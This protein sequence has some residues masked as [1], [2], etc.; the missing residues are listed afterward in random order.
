LFNSVP[1]KYID[2]FFHNSAVRL[3]AKSPYSPE[4]TMRLFLALILTLICAAAPV[5]AFADPT[6]EFQLE[7]R[8]YIERVA[9]L[10]RQ[11]LILQQVQ[12]ENP[13]VTVSLR[14]SAKGKFETERIE[15]GSGDPSF[16]M[17]VE[18]A[19]SKSIPILPVPP[20]PPG[21]TG[22]F[23]FSVRVCGGIC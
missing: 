23:T 5:Q 16:D 14:F 9:F 1:Q 3:A 7:Q 17:S 13:E 11:N 22:P 10:I 21:T 18:H 4:N 19:L 8:K 20:I 12:M 15:E 2:K 6:S